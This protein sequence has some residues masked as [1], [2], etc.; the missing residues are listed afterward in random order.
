MASNYS[1]KMHNNVQL[2]YNPGQSSHYNNSSQQ[3]RSIP[4]PAGIETSKK[5]YITVNQTS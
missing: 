2:T 4:P 1:G 5:S 3:V